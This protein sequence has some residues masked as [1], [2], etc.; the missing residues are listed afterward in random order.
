M[1]TPRPALR[2]PAV[3]QP[4]VGR[5]P[6]AARRR[7]VRLAHRRLRRSALMHQAWL[8]FEERL[9]RYMVR[10]ASSLLVV[11]HVDG[12]DR[13]GH[14]SPDVVRRITAR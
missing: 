9:D 8:E 7:L 12:K 6:A 5:T 4:R 1:V 14:L 11:E 10:W 13:V 3:R 2:S